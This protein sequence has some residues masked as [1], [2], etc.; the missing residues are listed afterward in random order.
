MGVSTAVW[1][2]VTF[3]TP[4]TE[5]AVLDAFYRQVRPVGAWGPVRRR[6][7]S[8]AAEGSLPVLAAWLSGIA[9]VYL[10]LFGLGKVLLGAPVVGVLLLAGGAA[11]GV[12]AYRFMLR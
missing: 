1:V 2:P 3:L 8:G 11:C 7:E 5:P 9:F 6:C 4:P 10:L 12:L